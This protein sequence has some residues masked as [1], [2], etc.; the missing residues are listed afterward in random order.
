MSAETLRICKATIEFQDFIKSAEKEGGS[1][2]LHEKGSIET[3]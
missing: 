3:I 2:K 1:D